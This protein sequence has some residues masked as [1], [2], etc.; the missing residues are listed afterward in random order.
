MSNI[1]FVLKL[2]RSGN[3][4]NAAR[5][6][7]D[8]S[9]D[10]LIQPGEEVTMSTIDGKVWL[11]D[12]SVGSATSGMQFLVKFIAPAGT[13]WSFTA[14]ANGATLHET[15]DQKTTTLKEALAGRLS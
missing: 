9:G 1:T 13:A 14:T 6:W 12:K 11:A 5:M 3:P 10:D 8:T 2:D 15:K 4:G 7:L